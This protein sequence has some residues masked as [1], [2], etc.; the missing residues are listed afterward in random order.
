MGFASE[1]L[2]T[3]ACDGEL[4]LLLCMDGRTL[5]WSDGV[6]GGVSWVVVA[7]SV[8]VEF[9]LGGDSVWFVLDVS[10]VVGLGFVGGGAVDP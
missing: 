1:V 8:D 5:F 7:C 4:D 6:G 10:V 3:S 2:G 9:F